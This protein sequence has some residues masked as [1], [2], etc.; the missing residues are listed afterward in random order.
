MKPMTSL[1]CSSVVV[2]LKS[3][4]ATLSRALVSSSAVGDEHDGFGELGDFG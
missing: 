2:S 3:G 4:L 1:V